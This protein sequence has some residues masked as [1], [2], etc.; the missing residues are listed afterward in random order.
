MLMSLRNLVVLVVGVLATDMF[1][2][3]VLVARLC[4]ALLQ[5]HTLLANH[6]NVWS[7]VTPRCGVTGAIL[8]RPGDTRLVMGSEPSRCSTGSVLRDSP[9]TE[10]TPATACPS[11]L[12]TNLKFLYGSMRTVSF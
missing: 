7:C 10:L 9:L 1:C 11:Q 6:S 12:T 2:P 3:L 4:C 8:V 5:N